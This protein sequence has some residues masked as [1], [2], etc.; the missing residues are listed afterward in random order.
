MFWNIDVFFLAKGRA[1]TCKDT[2]DSCLHYAANGDCDIDVD[3]KRRCPRSC[4]VCG[5]P[6]TTTAAKYTSPTTSAITAST[7]KTTQ[8]VTT[9][10]PIS[11][12][13]TDTSTI[14]GSS[15]SRTGLLRPN[16]GKLTSSVIKNYEI[17]VTPPLFYSSSTV[18]PDEQTTTNILTTVTIPIVETLQTPGPFI[19]GLDDS[20]PS[21]SV[22]RT[23]EGVTA[24]QVY[25]TSE[26]CC[27]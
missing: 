2:H 26:H 1:K 11:T 14:A 15:T 9:T 18:Q 17:R 3:T 25:P 23:T 5:T 20:R 10:T 24:G 12:I 27:I 21:V 4:N 19:Q 8:S 13:T 22:A 16:N 7:T 6:P